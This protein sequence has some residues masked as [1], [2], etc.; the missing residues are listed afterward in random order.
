MPVIN[1]KFDLACSIEVVEHIPDKSGKQLVKTLTELAPV[2]LLSAA[3]PYQGGVG[4]I[5]EQRQSYWYRVFR[6]YGYECIDLIRP[7]LWNNTDVNVIYRQNMFVYVNNSIYSN[8]SLKDLRITKSAQLDIIHPD[9][10]ERRMY[11]IKQK[12]AKDNKR[13]QSVRYTANQLVKAIIKKF[14]H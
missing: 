9:L 3:V 7:Q 13:K 4:H 2:V 1:K 5:N 14:N 10:F 6:D 8:L 11:K 12:N